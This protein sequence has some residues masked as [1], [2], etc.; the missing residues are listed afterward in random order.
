MNH[1]LTGYQTIC[2]LGVIMTPRPG[3]PRL[4]HSTRTMCSNMLGEQLLR[5]DGVSGLLSA[6]FGD[7]TDHDGQCSLV[8]FPNM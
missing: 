8:E 3:F 1:S 2:S 6:T 5:D 4:P 7:M